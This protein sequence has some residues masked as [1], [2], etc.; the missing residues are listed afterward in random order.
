MRLNH[1]P[2]RLHISEKLLSVLQKSYP[3]LVLNLSDLYQALVE[4]PNPEMG[5]LAFGCFIL[6]KA[7]RTSPAAVAKLLQDNLQGDEV[8]AQASALGPYLNLKI[9][10]SALGKNVLLPILNSQ[11]FKRA[12]SEKNQR[13]MIEYSQPNTHKE[14]HVGHMR[15]LCLGDALVRMLKYSG[16]EILTATF[17][18]DMG[19]HV[20][21]CL[22]YLKLHNKEAWPESHR[23]EWLG[24]MYSKAHIKLEDEEETSLF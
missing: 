1:D 20:A 12:L 16:G 4:P 8:I 17:P 15:N 7:L 6:S 24:R 18:G 21:K 11:Y 13:T 14:L 5:D 19:T 22:W 23:G 2:I 3:D 9:Q 10:I